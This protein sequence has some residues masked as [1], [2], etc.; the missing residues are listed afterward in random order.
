MSRKANPALIGAFVIGSV[1][2]VV[3]AVV[4]WGS[5]GLFERKYE[6]VC[7]FPGSVH[8]LDRGASVEY[9][10]VQIGVV[11]EVRLRFRQ[12]AEDRRIPVIVQLWGKRLR[13][14]GGSEPTPELVAALVEGGL[15]A[16]LAPSSLLTGVTY[17]SFDEAPGTPTHHSEL[18]GPGE[19]PEIPTLPS[20]F[21]E[22]TKSVTQ[23]V[24]NLTDADFRGMADSVTGAMQGVGQI[25]TSDDLHA[26][27]RELPR[28]LASA[29][30]LAKTLDA[31][32]V[33][34]GALVNDA[35]IALDALRSTLTDAHGVVAPD[36]PLSVDL[37]AA[38]SDVDKAAIAVR[39]LADFLRRNPHAIVAG[40][41]QRGKSP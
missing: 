33:N 31:D 32:A 36:A 3:V 39:E 25:T 13:E 28:A 19:V 12:P 17:V 27:M 6:Y 24:A 35:Q 37:G 14:L 40:T 15:R 8:G 7:Y 26:A 34:A 22:I 29:H 9:R 30:R 1:V 21:E 41:K 20:E 11:K 18:A 38:V 2:L 5:R 23:F 10:G 4:I 16:R